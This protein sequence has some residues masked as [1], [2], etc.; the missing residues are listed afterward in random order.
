MNAT[1][2]KYQVRTVSSGHV[3]V[4]QVLKRGK[5]IKQF[6]GVYANEDTHDYVQDCIQHDN[7]TDIN[8][9]D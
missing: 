5:V 9:Q 1:K 3:Q 6:E 2:F 7:I 8:F 4:V